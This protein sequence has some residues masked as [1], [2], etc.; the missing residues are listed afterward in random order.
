MSP[1][2]RPGGVIP[3]VIDMG[4]GRSGKG[5]VKRVPVVDARGVPLMPTTPVRARRML[6]EGEAVARRN[7]LGI[8]YIQLKRAVDPVPKGVQER[9]QPIAASVDLGSS[10]AGLSVVGTKDTILNIMTEPVN[11]VE[12]ALRKRREMRRLRRY[13]KCRRRKKRF[14]NRKRPEGWVP[15]STKARWDTYLRIIDHLRKIVPIT[16]VGVEEGKARTKKGQKRWNNN[17]SPLQNGRNY[18]I[19]ELQKRGLSVTLLPAREVARLRKKHGLTKVKDKAEKSFYSHCVDA[20]V[21]S[22]WI[23]GAATSN[24]LDIWYAVPL[25]FHRRQLH[26][27]KPS[28]G[29]VRKRYG[30]TR[31]LGFKRGTLVKSGYGLCYIGGFDEKRKRLSLHDVKTGK[32][33][34]KAAKPDDIRVLTSVSFRSFY[35]P[36]IPP[37]ACG[38]L[39]G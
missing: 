2:L 29:G 32:R 8:F 33:T 11:W 34:T 5:T 10:F 22:A 27:L 23:T 6:K 4:K 3:K 30:G 21:I 38:T 28:K 1:G 16:H 39:A 15:P 19:K 18:F 14:D 37:Q 24:C 26:G 36:A 35:I 17:F 31:S 20:W 9:T 25:R 13:R 7:K 12:D